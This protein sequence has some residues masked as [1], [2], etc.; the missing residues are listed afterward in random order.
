MVASSFSIIFCSSSTVSS[1]FIL[2][3]FLIFCAFYPNLKVEIVYEIWISWGE[4]VTIKVVLEFP[5]KESFIILVNFDYLYG[6]WVIL[7]ERLL[8]TLPKLVK[9][10][11]IFFAC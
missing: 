5:P 4:Q 7:Y 6:T 1:R 11:L 9:D 3:L 10:R 8:I 2:G